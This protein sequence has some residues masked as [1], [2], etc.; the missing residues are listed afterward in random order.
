MKKLYAVVPAL[1]LVFFA[2]AVLAAASDSCDGKAG[3][4]A[5]FRGSMAPHHRF[6][7]GLNL[8][9]EQKEK[10]HEIE[11]RFHADTRDLRYDLEQRRLEMRK[12]FTD[13]KTGETALLAKEREIGVLLQKMFEKRAQKKIE[14][15]RI[16]TPEQIRQL[17]RMPMGPEHGPMVGPHTGPAMGLHMGPGASGFGIR[18]Q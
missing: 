18:D 1:F 13:P 10:I 4:P 9:K 7:D 11:A 16:L 15:R 5:K 12:L 3:E 2:T 17:D 6:E 14:S 8:S